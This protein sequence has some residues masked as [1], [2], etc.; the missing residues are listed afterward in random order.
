MTS[1]PFV[2]TT[3][4]VHCTSPSPSMRVPDFASD[5]A[6]VEEVFD[7]TGRPPAGWMHALFDGGP[8]ANRCT[9][10]CR[11]NAAPAWKVCR[12]VRSRPLTCGL[13]RPCVRGIDRLWLWLMARIGAG[14]YE[15]PRAGHIARRRRRRRY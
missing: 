2:M 6:D 15:R 11:T 5:D 14:T 3:S 12:Y 13:C 10:G 7:T 8:F 9:L 4:I 1:Q